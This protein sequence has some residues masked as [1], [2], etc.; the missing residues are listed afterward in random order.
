MSDTEIV[1][2]PVVEP[3]VEPEV[4]VPEPEPK[5]ELDISEEDIQAAIDQALASFDK[6]TEPVSFPKEE[7]VKEDLNSEIQAL[8]KQKESELESTKSELEQ[9]ESAWQMLNQAIPDLPDVLTKIVA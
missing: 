8:L 1:E 6:P 7:A 2:A 4:P 9:V 3:V 5:I